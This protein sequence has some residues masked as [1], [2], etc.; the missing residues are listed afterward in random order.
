MAVFLFHASFHL[1]VHHRFVVYS[2][3]TIREVQKIF[4]KISFHT[5]FFRLFWDYLH[6]RQK[7]NTNFLNGKGGETMGNNNE[8]RISNQF[9]AFCTRV[10]K[11]EARKI[12]KAYAAQRKREVSLAELTPEQARQ[13]S[14]EDKYFSDQHIFN[15][16]G[17]EIV[18]V[19]NLLAEAIRQLP[20]E[21]RNIILL[22][23]FAEMTDKE[24]GVLL[25][26]YQQSI[27][28]RRAASLKLLREYFAK[29]GIEWDDM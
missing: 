14:G 19:G 25:R 4:Y 6:E 24:I 18:V 15:V 5:V 12:Y 20:Q 7:R 3:L 10:L 28:R 22:S 9:G 29:E 16:L 21:K 8:K 13:L 23:Y 1:P 26:S 17:K 11:N 2:H 27:C